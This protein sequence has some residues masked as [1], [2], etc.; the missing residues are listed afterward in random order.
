MRLVIRA[1]SQGADNVTRT[2]RAATFARRLRDA[3]VRLSIGKDASEAMVKR[4]AGKYDVLHFA[5]HGL[6][7]PERP[8]TSS[9]V[10]GADA[11]EDGYLR[12]DETFNLDL[13][14]ELV[15]LSGCSTGLGKLT[16]DGIVGLTRAFLYAGTPT[17]MVSQ[18]NVSDRATSALM[19]RF[20]LEWRRG[21]SKAQAL[22][23]AMLAVR[24]QFPNP[25]FWAAFEVVGEP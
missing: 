20:Y 4:E 17:V 19:D 6:V 23:T 11:G 14:A 22:R 13:S 25:A 9:I 1:V 10:L 16:G 21:A 8:L 7:A 12:V 2:I 15:V 5:T 18:W 24:K 3:P